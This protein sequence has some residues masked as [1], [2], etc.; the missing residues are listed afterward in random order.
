MCNLAGDA[1]KQILA[2]W[3]D[4]EAGS[5]AEARF[6]KDLDKLEMLCQARTYEQ[7]QPEVDLSDFY[8]STSTYAFNTPVCKALDQEVRRRK[9]QALVE[10]GASDP[11]VPG[12]VD[13]GE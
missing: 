6:V 5:S 13:D 9:R 11:V 7:E 10:S 4:F 1:G 12:L 2:L 3:E 8:R